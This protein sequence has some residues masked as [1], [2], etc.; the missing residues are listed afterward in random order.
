MKKK[1]KVTRTV[2]KIDML[3]LKGYAALMASNGIGLT[4][5]Q[6]AVNMLTEILY[7]QKGDVT[8]PLTPEECTNMILQGGFK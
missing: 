8:R 2:Y 6:A 4:G 3:K 1:K 7:A 5:Y